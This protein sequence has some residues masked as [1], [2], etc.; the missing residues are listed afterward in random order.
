MLPV[1]KQPL[2]RKGVVIQPWQQTVRGRTDDIGLRVVDVQIH[3]ARGDDAPG[4]V[5]YR[6]ARGKLTQPRPGTD[7]LDHAA[8]PRIGSHQE[9]SIGIELG[10]AIAGK[11]QDR[12]TVGLHATPSSGGAGCKRA[13][14]WAS[15]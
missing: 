12:G 3:E 14:A 4:Q 8:P 10:R 1:G 9:Q 7:R 11:P 15:T 13:I 6:Q 5:L 2:L